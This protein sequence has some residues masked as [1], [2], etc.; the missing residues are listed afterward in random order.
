MVALLCYTKQTIDGWNYFTV[1]MKQQR[2]M[3]LLLRPQLICNYRKLIE[4]LFRGL[5]LHLEYRKNFIFII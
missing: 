5:S 3:L 4:D 2:V 1:I